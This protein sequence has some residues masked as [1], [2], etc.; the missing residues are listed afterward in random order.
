MIR[1]TRCTLVKRGLCDPPAVTDRCRIEFRK[2]SAN[3]PDPINPSPADMGVL[4][5]AKENR[6][7]DLFHAIFLIEV[8]HGA[9]KCT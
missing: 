1:S 7:P 4:R 3:T 8:R 2:V 5:G 6:T 9:P